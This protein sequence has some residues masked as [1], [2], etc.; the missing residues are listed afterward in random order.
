MKTLFSLYSH[1]FGPFSVC[2]GLASKPITAVVTLFFYA[3]WDTG[4]QEM[5]V[6]QIKQRGTAVSAERCLMNRRKNLICYVPLWL[7]AIT[8][9]AQG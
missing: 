5:N 6:A 9:Q 1:D 2:Y 3:N 7:N 8:A 4:S